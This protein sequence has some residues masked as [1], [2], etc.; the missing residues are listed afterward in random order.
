MICPNC[1]R[2][3]LEWY[4]GGE[5]RNYEADDMVSCVNCGYNGER[6]RGRDYDGEEENHATE[7]TSP[8]PSPC[9]VSDFQEVT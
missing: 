6:E 3:T 2:N 9:V 8:L 1:G 4:D 7:T 5:A